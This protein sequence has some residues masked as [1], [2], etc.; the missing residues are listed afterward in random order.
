MRVELQAQQQAETGAQGRGEQ[1]GARGGAD[2]GEGLHVHGV[3]AR[4]RALA[5]HDVEL[6]V[7]ERGVEDFF[8]RG[9]Q[10]MDFVDEEHLAVAKI[11]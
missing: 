10:A 1:S 3:S 2:E 9:L 4:G 6:V 5:D 11:G 7:F 8:E